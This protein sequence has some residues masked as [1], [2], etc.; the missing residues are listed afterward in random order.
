MLFKLPPSLIQITH[1]FSP[2]QWAM[3][4][5]IIVLSG[6]RGGYSCNRCRKPV[7]ILRHKDLF[8]PFFPP[9]FPP[10]PSPLFYCKFKGLKSRLKTTTIQKTVETSSTV[11]VLLCVHKSVKLCLGNCI[12]YWFM[13]CMYLFPT[14]PVSNTNILETKTC[15][16]TASIKR[17][18]NLKNE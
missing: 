9:P 18:F 7:C 3:L 12:A 10:S 5:C 11:N 2:H 8:S 13:D 1:K 6:I 15:W 16:Q 14:L 17:D 4:L